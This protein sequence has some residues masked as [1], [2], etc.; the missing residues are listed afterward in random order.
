MKAFVHTI[1]VILLF[2]SCCTNTANG[3]GMETFSMVD[4]VGSDYTANA[5]AIEQKKQ[6]CWLLLIVLA[7]I[8]SL[9]YGV[10]VAG[11]S[12]LLVDEP[13]DADDETNRYG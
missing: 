4:G 5:T 1:A 7:I 13:N 10:P 6:G 9:I 2:A 11:S 8:G 3:I 12:R